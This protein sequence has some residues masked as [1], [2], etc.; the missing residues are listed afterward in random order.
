MTLLQ[1]FLCCSQEH[2]LAFFEAALYVYAKNTNSI[3]K[4]FEKYNGRR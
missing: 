2:L 4:L 3:E 1:V